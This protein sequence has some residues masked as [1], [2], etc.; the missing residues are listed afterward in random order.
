MSIPG[1]PDNQI[2]DNINL[3]K[4]QLAVDI[5]TGVADTTALTKFIDSMKAAGITDT[6]TIIM[7]CFNVVYSL[8]KNSDIFNEL[9]KVYPDSA[10]DISRY[11]IIFFKRYASTGTDILT[12]IKEFY[13]KYG[14]TKEILLTELDFLIADGFKDIE[15]ITYIMNKCNTTTTK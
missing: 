4:G 7:G 15:R 14:E 5:N 2:Q 8:G 9:I 6:D 1:N 11:S 3:A 13:T 12:K 10:E